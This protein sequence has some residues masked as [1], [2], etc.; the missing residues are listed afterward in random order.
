MRLYLAKLIERRCK[1]EDDDQAGIEAL[2]LSWEEP[3]KR[4]AADMELSA[5][6]DQGLQ[7]P[8]QGAGRARAAAGA[9]DA[10]PEAGSRRPRGAD[11]R[12]RH[13][14][15]SVSKR[16]SAACPRSALRLQRR[17][18]AQE[19]IARRT[20]PRSKVRSRR[21]KRASYRQGEDVVVSL[22][23]IKF[24]IRPQHHRRHS[25]PLM[26]QGEA[27]VGVVPRRVH[28]R[29]KATPTRTAATPRT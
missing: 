26:Q 18:D 11:R 9:G 6:F 21:M 23:G 8:M 24:P 13:T 27:G 16:G 2:M 15:C 28:C 19:R 3:L 22:L 5:R 20:S 4:M 7:P 17:V 25:A 29:S 10:S 12:A 1:Q 14:D